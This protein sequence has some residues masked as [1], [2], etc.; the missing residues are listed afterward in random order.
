M[1]AA[2]IA[3]I[4]LGAASRCEQFVYVTVG[5]GIAFTLMVGRASPPGCSR[6]AI[7]LG[8]P[9]VERVAS[10]PAIAA[11]AGTAT[12]EEAFGDPEAAGVITEAAC[13]LGVALAWLNNALDPGA[14]RGRRRPRDTPDFLAAAVAS[15]NAAVVDAGGHVVDVR[16]ASLGERSAAIGAAIV[17]ADLHR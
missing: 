16:P 12:A 5:T 7:L 2:A 13:Q 9:P 17:A 10:G 8:V 14:D 11:Q 15:M 3:E 1:R 4:R 6:N